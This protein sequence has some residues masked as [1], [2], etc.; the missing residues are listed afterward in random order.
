MSAIRQILDID[1]RT[2]SGK[3]LRSSLTTVRA[4]SRIVPS[5]HV[6]TY[7][8]LLAKSLMCGSP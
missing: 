3:A 8:A 1:D 6:S 2:S 4:R 7:S 5:K